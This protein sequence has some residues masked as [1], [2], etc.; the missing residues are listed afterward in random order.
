[1]K[2]KQWIEI[3]GDVIEIKMLVFSIILSSL[4]TL[5]GYF[6]APK[7]DSAKQLF[8]GLGGALIGFIISS[9]LIKPKRMILN[10]NPERKEIN[11]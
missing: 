5:G 11:G 3:W 9:L 1:M 8:F 10:A 4:T 6:L 7:D 2:E